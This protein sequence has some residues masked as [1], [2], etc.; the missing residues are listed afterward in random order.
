MYLD[1]SIIGYILGLYWDNGKE[2]GNYYSIIGNTLG[3]YWDNGKFVDAVSSRALDV[4]SVL[5]AECWWVGALVPKPKYRSLGAKQGLP[6]PEYMPLFP[7]IGGEESRYDEVCKAFCCAR[8]GN[9][10]FGFLKCGSQWLFFKYAFA[11]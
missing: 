11:L 1:F 10:V 9:E 2:N 5:Q 6:K 4:G 8:V 3:L 7:R